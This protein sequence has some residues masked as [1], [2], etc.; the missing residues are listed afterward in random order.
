MVSAQLAPDDFQQSIFTTDVPFVT[1]KYLVPI[2]NSY[3]IRHC[4]YICIGVHAA[5]PYPDVYPHSFIPG[6]THGCS[7]AD[8][9]EDQEITGTE[10][11]Q[12]HATADAS[13]GFQEN[14]LSSTTSVSFDTALSAPPPEIHINNQLDNK[15]AAPSTAP[16]MSAYDLLQARLAALN[17]SNDS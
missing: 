2:S 17:A 3:I 15:D 14:T 8:S 13:S 5:V 16:A 7:F 10:E 4:Q 6:S 9:E 12:G 11:H 1:G